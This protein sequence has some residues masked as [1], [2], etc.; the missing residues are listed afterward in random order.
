MLNEIIALYSITNKVEGKI[1]ASSWAAFPEVDLDILAKR[2]NILDEE[3][4]DIYLI[5][6]DAESTVRDYIKKNLSLD[7]A[8]YAKEDSCIT[9]NTSPVIINDIRV[10]NPDDVPAITPN[11]VPINR[12]S[13]YISIEFPIHINYVGDCYKKIEVVVDTKTFYSQFQ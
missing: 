12:T 7:D 1:I 9:L 13:I 6:A 4:R 11:G 2:H 3:K 8:Y 5:K 10:Y